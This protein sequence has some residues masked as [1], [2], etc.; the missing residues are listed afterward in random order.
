MIMVLPI[1]PYIGGFDMNKKKYEFT[2]DHGD[3]DIRKEMVRGQVAYYYYMAGI[4]AGWRDN[5]WSDFE[6]YRRLDIVF[7]VALNRAMESHDLYKKMFEP[8][9]VESA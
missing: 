5:A 4:S 3:C 2:Y 9:E 1:A 8:E 6:S 7:L